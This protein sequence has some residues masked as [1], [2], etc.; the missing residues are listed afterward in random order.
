MIDNSKLETSIL[1]KCIELYQGVIKERARFDA[2]NPK[3]DIDYGIPPQYMYVRSYDSV[4]EME[5]Y[6]KHPFVKAWMY[7]GGVLD[8]WTEDESSVENIEIS[9][10]YYKRATGDFSW[11]PDSMK[12]FINMTYGPRYARGYSFDIRIEEDNICLENEDLLWVS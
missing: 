1:N 9:G 7:S 3:H 8:P 11:D 12:V 6:H 10:M 5:N 4:E 2:E